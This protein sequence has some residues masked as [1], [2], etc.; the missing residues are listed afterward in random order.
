MLPK[1]GDQAALRKVWLIASMVVLWAIAPLGNL[2]LDPHILVNGPDIYGTPMNV[3][4]LGVDGIPVNVNNL[5]VNGNQT[6]WTLS[7]NDFPHYQISLLGYLGPFSNAHLLLPTPN[8]SLV[9]VSTQVPYLSP[10]I[11]RAWKHRTLSNEFGTTLLQGRTSF[12]L[13]HDSY[14]H[15]SCVFVLAKWIPEKTPPNHFQRNFLN[16][17]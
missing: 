15:T 11:A 6:D 17:F 7:H 13:V 12:P 4:G 8:L 14:L 9:C 2:N 10:H 3:N 5:D 16:V 1:N